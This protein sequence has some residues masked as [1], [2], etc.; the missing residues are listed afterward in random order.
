M[1]QV[2]GRMLD[3]D[4]SSGKITRSDIAPDSARSFLG[5]MGL[6]ARLLYDEVG[7]DVDPLGPGN[8]I[9]FAN[10]PLTGTRA[11]SSGRT[12]ITT[13]FPLTGNIGS[14]NTG[15]LWGTTL[16]RAGIDLLTVR[17]AAAEPVYLRI[18]DDHVEIR[19]AGH[20]WGQPTRATTD[21][22]R[23]ELGPVSVLAIGPAGENLVKYACPL[24]D[25]YHVAARCGAG[26]V[27]G[28][29]KLKAITVRGT[30]TP[31]IARPEEFAQA[32]RDARERVLTSEEAHK[33]YAA[34]LE[35]R[36]LGI[37]A[38][39]LPGRNFQTGVVP[40]WL[41]T[42]GV[43]AARKYF[44]KRDGTCYACPVPCFNLAEVTEG[45]YAGLRVNRSQMPGVV[46]CWGAKCAIDN[47]EAV[48][49][50]K[51]TCQ[52]LGM[53]YESAG[54]T[55]AFA[56][57][58]YQR[59]II[60]RSDT[61]GLDLTWGNEDAIIE[62]LDKIA[63]R[64]G[65]GNVLAEGSVKAAQTIGG[66]AEKYVMAVKGLELGMLPDPRASKS[67]KGWM[68]DS[69][70]SPRGG[71]NIKGTHFRADT[72]DPNWWTDKF[73]I[74]EEEKAKMYCVPDE[75]TAFRWEGKALMCRW[76]EDL[77]SAVSSSGLCFY[78]FLIKM[79]LGPTYLSRM[80]AAATGWDIT[81][82]E[83]MQA[84]ERSF[85][86]LKAYSVRQGFRRKDDMWPERFFTEP[87]PEGPDKGAVLSR[88]TI[89]RVLDEY[90]DLRGWDRETGVPT[91][92][93]LKELGLKDIG[94]DLLRMDRIP[95]G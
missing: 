55:I 30:G 47:I 12:E 94:A 85:N 2:Y 20:L 21:M 91:F 28:S 15:G 44:K 72:Y 10:G 88:D 24:N 46:L 38:G 93:K 8:V 66:G 84:G 43:D 48:W 3:V 83:V 31:G 36:R 19:K 58:L 16:R 35:P 25:Y 63:R 45:K 75:E 34:S 6:A 54:C 78:P 1:A 42:R 17:G 18:D 33:E 62:L 5:S 56:M 67:E 70:T 7:E 82:E 27:M 77:A 29:K 57:E 95:S 65:F 60:T 41:E 87:L 37:E 39:N 73:D 59:G 52:E 81:P 40:R 71:D 64:E 90:Y 61:D 4:L 26:A 69:L 51:E 53:D 14:G 80:L 32:T 23:E 74:F 13:K 92:R 86:M 11:P 89:N 22:L 49:K 68:F 79:A 50:C 9:I 76:F